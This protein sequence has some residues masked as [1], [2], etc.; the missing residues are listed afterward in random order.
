VIP[1]AYVGL[2]SYQTIDVL[3]KS[4]LSCIFY[5]NIMPHFS[6]GL[7]LVPHL[8]RLQFSANAMYGTSPLRL[9]LETRHCFHVCVGPRVRSSRGRP[10]PREPC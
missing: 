5:H 8:L 4:M 1:K 7:T 10:D 2:M 6:P 9:H 3:A